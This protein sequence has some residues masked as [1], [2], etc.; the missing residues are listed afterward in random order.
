MHT[1]YF[2]GCALPAE[3]QVSHIVLSYMAEVLT[4]KGQVQVMKEK[5]KISVFF[6][7]CNDTQFV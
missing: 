6:V 7:N 1:R 4:R 2:K 5:A 3:I